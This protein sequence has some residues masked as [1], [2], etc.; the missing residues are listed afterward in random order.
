MRDAIFSICSK[1]AKRDG[2]KAIRGGIPL[3]FPIFG[4]KEK[5]ALPQHGKIFTNKSGDGKI[6]T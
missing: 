2:S 4:T 3:C 6:A 1:E 5:I